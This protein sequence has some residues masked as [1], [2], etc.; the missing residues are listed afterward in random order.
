MAKLINAKC[1]NCGAILELPENLDRAFCMHCGGKVIIAKDVHVGGT[2]IACPDC[3]GKGSFPCV[4]EEIYPFGMFYA[5]FKML[6][7]S[8]TVMWKKQ[9]ELTHFHIKATG[10]DKTG[11][12]RLVPLVSHTSQ[13]LDYK[14]NTYYHDKKEYL[15]GCV[16]GKCMKC[17]GNGEFGIFSKKTC[18]ACGGTGKCPICN[19]SG[20]CTLC[21]DTGKVKCEPCNGTGFK[22]Y[23]GE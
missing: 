7:D 20:V 21:N 8:K 6:F 19:G 2:A 18:D 5:G 22:M 15:V 3:E 16:K 4:K 11:R 12:C 9:T 13:F 14:A 10:C 23:E 1:P 17:K